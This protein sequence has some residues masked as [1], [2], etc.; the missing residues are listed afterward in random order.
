M[1]E[2]EDI[3]KELSGLPRV[4][5]VIAKEVDDERQ[6]EQQQE[7]AAAAENQAGRSTGHA[8]HARGLRRSTGRVNRNSLTVR[9]ELSVE[10][11]RP[12]GSTEVEVGRPAGST[13]SRVWA[14][15]C[16]SANL[17]I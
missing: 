13:D 16:C 14:K 11:G 10:F 3:A 12:G 5:E 9:P 15:I 4:V 8:Q 2:R 17:G 7:I 1:L 6:R